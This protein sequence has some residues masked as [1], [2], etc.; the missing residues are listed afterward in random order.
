LAWSV[1]DEGYSRHASLFDYS[2]ELWDNCG[3]GNSNKL[4]Q[5]KLE[6]VRIVARLPIVTKIEM[7]Y[8]E[9]GW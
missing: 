9:I 7:L 5:H 3:I 4:E 6:G 2:C 1:P 8:R